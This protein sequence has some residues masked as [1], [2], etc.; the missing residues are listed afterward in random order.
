MSQTDDDFAVDSYAPMHGH[1][2]VIMTAWAKVS[3]GLVE[4][5]AVIPAHLAHPFSEHEAAG[6]RVVNVTSVPCA[7]GY[8]VDTHG[9]VAPQG[10]SPMPSQGA[11]AVM[12]QE[13]ASSA[14][15]ETVA[16][17]SEPSLEEQPHPE[18]PPPDKPE[19]E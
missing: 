14:Q 1:H 7:V 13:V 11:Q 18:L 17:E 5:I 8:V 15:D 19:G 10:T 9:N 2:N 16:T 3:G 4:A 12:T 6:G